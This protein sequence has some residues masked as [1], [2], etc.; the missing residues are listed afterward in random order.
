M[1]QVI[2]IFLVEDDPYYA[3]LL[4]YHLGANPENYIEVFDNGCDLLSNLYRNPDIISLDYGLPDINGKEVLEK[5]KEFNLNIPV[6]MV[7]G[8]GELAVAVELFKIGAYDYII[9]GEDTKERLWNAVE[10]IKEQ[11]GLKQE[12]QNLR[13]QISTKYRLELIQGNSE[14]I[15][16]MS[17]MIESAIKS[18]LP[19][20]ISGEVGS[21][22][23]LIAKS[24]HY[25]SIRAE[26]PFIIFST[27]IYNETNIEL[28][29]F[30][31]EKDA[32]PGLPYRKIGKL[33]EANGGTLYIEEICDLDSKTQ[34][35]ILNFLQEKEICRIGSKRLVKLDVRIIASTSKD[36]E[37]E[38]Q[39]GNFRKDLFYRIIGI[40]I[41]VPPLR[42]RGNDIIEIANRFIN[43]YCIENNLKKAKLLP[44]AQTKL[45]NHTYP[46]NV[47]ELRSI[48]ELAITV[49]QKGNIKAENIT[50]TNENKNT[51]VLFEDKTLDE[52]EMLIIKQYMIKYNNNV[53]TVS[54][55][56]NVAKSTVYRFLKKSNCIIV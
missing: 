22:K 51:F 48:I 16:K 13:A 38:V 45:L 47:S 39:N 52:Y 2:K 53:N 46:G 27:T 3:K 41:S 1:K 18:K 10:R 19:V 49:C 11:I 28:E 50:F 56:L 9:K 34:L 14:G 8:Q 25:N 31:Y 12:I 32:I 17:L 55:K 5:I 33:E 54:E 42:Q 20:V 6:V 24:I 36:L 4:H 23:A 30:G 21:G 43:E 44:D 35:K 29:L 26:Q 15:R 40:P 37:K 7:S